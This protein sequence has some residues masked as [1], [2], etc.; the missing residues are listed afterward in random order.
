M[1]LARAE[2]QKKIA[3]ESR[4]QAELRKEKEKDEV[5]EKAG[6]K[7]KTTLRGLKTFIYSSDS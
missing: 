7:P 5:L 1:A 6:I 2:Q 4:K 3:E